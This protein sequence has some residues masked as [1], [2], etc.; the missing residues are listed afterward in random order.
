MT[1]VRCWQDDCKFWKDS[2]CTSPEIEY[3][4]DEGC[5]TAEE[6]EEIDEEKEELLLEDEEEEEGDE[7]FFEDEE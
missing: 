3:Y 6:K 5:V 7:G 2:L 4:P 1:K